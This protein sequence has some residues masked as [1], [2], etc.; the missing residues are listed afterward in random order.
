[1]KSGSS[2]FTEQSSLL[3]LK[4]GGLGYTS[5]ALGATFISRHE[6]INIPFLLSQWRAEEK[7]PCNLP[8]FSRI[9]MA[10]TCTSETWLSTG[11]PGKWERTT[12]LQEVGKRLQL[13]L[14]T[15]KQSSKPFL[16]LYNQKYIHYVD[17]KEQN[18]VTVALNYTALLASLLIVANEGFKSMNVKTSTTPLLST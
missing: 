16:L 8:S 14:E 6:R 7:V 10:A 13:N 11:D 18:P 1:M 17:F 3:Q 12:V 4:T 5:Y 15:K 2:I 9:P